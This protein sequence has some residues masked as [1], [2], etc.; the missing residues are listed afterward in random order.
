MIITTTDLN[1]NVFHANNHPTGGVK[2]TTVNFEYFKGSTRTVV[3][4]NFMATLISPNI[5][6]WELERLRI[7][8]ENRQNNETNYASVRFQDSENRVR[9]DVYKGKYSEVE[10]SLNEYAVLAE[11]D[12]VRK[13]L[14]ESNFVSLELLK[15]EHMSYR[16]E[17]V[18]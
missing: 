9:T 8:K 5:F 3:T 13:Q 7:G 4:Y 18:I 1:N 11:Y 6:K 17:G 16:V 15:P 2:Y 12:R 10:F 14:H